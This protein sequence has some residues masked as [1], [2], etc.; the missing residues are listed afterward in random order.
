MALGLSKIFS[1]DDVD[2]PMRLSVPDAL[3]FLPIVVFSFPFPA[4]FWILLTFLF[5]SFFSLSFVVA[6]D[7]I[8]G[9][10]IEYFFFDET[11]VS[12]NSAYGCDDFFGTSAAEETDDGI[13]IT[14]MS[15]RISDEISNVDSCNGEPFLEFKCRLKLLRKVIKIS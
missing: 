7:K 15:R 3:I 5:L 2:F 1:F 13:R 6:G 12:G 9:P 10:G 4:G 8:I 11:G 14:F